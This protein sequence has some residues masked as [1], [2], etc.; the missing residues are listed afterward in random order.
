[1]KVKENIIRTVVLL[2]G[3]G[4]YEENIS[5]SDLEA[6]RADIA[7]LNRFFLKRGISQEYIHILIDS[8]ATKK[9]IISTI[10]QTIFSQVM[11]EDIRL[12]FFFSGH[13]VIVE[14]KGIPPESVLITYDTNYSDILSTGILISELVKI[15]KRL[16]V[17]ELYIFLDACFMSINSIARTFSE[18]PD[19]DLFKRLDT[20]NSF[21]CMVANHEAV[22]IEP[23]YG[24]LGFFTNT[25]IESIE[26]LEKNKNPSLSKLIEKIQNSYSLNN[27]GNPYVVVAGA[28]NNWPFLKENEKNKISNLNFTKNKDLLIEREET[29]QELTFFLRKNSP[30]A[31]FIL[32]ESGIGKTTL[33]Y[34]FSQDIYDAIFIHITKKD[35]FENILE[36]ILLSIIK[37][38][39]FN[40]FNFKSFLN[41][42]DNFKKLIQYSPQL[43]LCIDGI[44][45]LEN[46]IFKKVLSFF[47]KI[48]IQICATLINKDI[49][50]LFMLKFECPPFS[51]DETKKIVNKYKIYETSTIKMIYNKSKGSPLRIKNLIVNPKINIDS[52]EKIFIKYIEVIKNIIASSGYIDKYEFSK[53]MNVNISDLDTLEELGYIN[54]IDKIWFVHDELLRFFNKETISNIYYIN[55]MKYWCHEKKSWN[56]H[57]TPSIRIIDLFIRNNELF[58]NYDKCIADSLEKIYT[59]KESPLNIN[60]LFNILK[61]NYL[62]YIITFS[63]LM[64]FFSDLGDISKMGEIGKV[65]NYSLE[66]PNKSILSLKLSFA[67]LSWWAGDYDNCINLG[68][69]VIDNKDSSNKL[70]CKANL[71]VSIGYF[72]LGEWDKSNSLL[73]TILDSEHSSGKVFA[74][75]KLIMGTID[76]IRGINFKESKEYLDSSIRIL[77][78]END[79]YGLAI[80][81][82]NLG[83]ALWKAKRYEESNTYLD[84]CIKYAQIVNLEINLIE[85]KRNKLQLYIRWKNPFSKIVNELINELI[86]LETSK[87]GTMEMMQVSNTLATAYIYQKNILEAKKYIKIAFDL[88][89]E[90]KEYHIYTLGNQCLLSILEKENST[91]IKLIFKELEELVYEGNNFFA[92]EQVKDDL[93]YL[94][95]TYGYT[96]VKQLTEGINNEF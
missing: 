5:S 83:E 93:N 59:I 16:F 18:I 49:L 64:E 26:N 3:I 50:S 27:I 32:G 68:K 37:D 92:L 78:D 30:R 58:Y 15:I 36:L 33:L 13:G 55:S 48:N 14:E 69:S 24:G 65:I 87:I 63:K 71:E 19:L 82:G 91:K 25:I 7:W 85:G 6:T 23:V 40:C 46:D 90:N 76:S 60:E 79:L 47:E 22:T 72:F 52:K 42:E 54:K 80:A 11:E 89:L 1:M 86:L 81:Y 75:S 43:I 21:L 94:Y 44:E 95:N 45:Y 12:F 34:E 66:N 53:K 31:I 39:S 88:T 70:I 84:N 20:S 2:I 35:N 57:L 51:Y 62:N 8:S 61:K 10:R 56:R 17:K 74:W 28:I 67:R 38:K 41:I 9:N 29:I 96:I 4:K 77:A 73:Q